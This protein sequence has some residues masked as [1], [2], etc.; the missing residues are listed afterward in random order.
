MFD[1]RLCNI[2]TYNHKGYVVKV[3]CRGHE[4]V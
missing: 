1:L 3:A 4:M 2:S